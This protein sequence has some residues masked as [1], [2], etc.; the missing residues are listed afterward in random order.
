MKS[1]QYP[2][3]DLKRRVLSWAVKLKVNPR[4]VRVQDMRRKW[5]SCSSTGTITLA[6]DLLDQEQRFQDYVIVHELLHL[7][8]ATHGRMFKALMSAY[9]P[10]WRAMEGTG[11]HRFAESTD[12]QEA[13]CDAGG[14]DEHTVRHRTRK[15]G[16]SATQHGT[17]AVHV[18]SSVSA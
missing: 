2:A 9:V 3:Q 5:G 4:A 10:G 8:L 11:Q 15:K 18:E 14:I 16:N 12:R 17:V 7:R 13:R 1:S 6:S